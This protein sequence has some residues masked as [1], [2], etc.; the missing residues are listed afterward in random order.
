MKNL[1][2]FLAFV[3]MV[4][5]AYAQ[6]NL[7]ACQGRDVAKWSNCTGEETRSA[8]FQYKGEF[9]DGKRHGLGVMSVLHPNFN[10][11]K[12]VG[13]WKAGKRDGQGTYTFANGNKYVGEFKDGRYNGQGTYTFASGEKF[14]GEFKDG[15]RNGQ[16]TNTLANGNKY[17]G[18]Y[19]DDKRNGQGTF[20]SNGSI[21]NQGIW[22]DDNFV[23]SEPVQQASAPLVQPSSAERDRLAA[24]VEAELK[25]REEL[26]R[27]LTEAN[28][29]K[30]ILSDLDS[31]LGR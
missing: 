25:K 31:L 19:K 21:I 14:I 17:V 15:K 18:E 1:R 30:K 26:E 4:G 22:A 8:E 10:G 23:R 27:Q 20:Y 12:Y 11:D 16:G 5:G 28:R 13:E 3:L 29:R 9:L 2:R 6:S 7:P 24:Q